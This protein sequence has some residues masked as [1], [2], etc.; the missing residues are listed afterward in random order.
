MPSVTWVTT[1]RLM[2]ELSAA[3]MLTSRSWVSGRS[4]VRPWRRIAM[5][6]A[7]DGPIQIGRYRSRSDSLRM[8]TCWL[9]SMWTRTLSTTISISRTRPKDFTH[10]PILVDGYSRTT[11]TTLVGGEQVRDRRTVGDR[12]RREVPTH[13]VEEAGGRRRCAAP[14]TGATKAPSARW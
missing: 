8:T 6:F 11:R 10:G 4:A 1:T 7:S 2:L 9:E 14:A 3:T 5:A 12:G 13:I